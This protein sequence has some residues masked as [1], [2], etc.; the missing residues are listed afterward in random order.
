VG[1][2]SE[3]ESLSKQDIADLIDTIVNQKM[4]EV[5]HKT[6][7]KIKAAVDPLSQKIDRIDNTINNNFQAF[8][9]TINQN[10]TDTIT[11]MFQ[12]FGMHQTTGLITPPSNLAP[13]STS[14]RYAALS[15]SQTY[16]SPTATGTA[17][18]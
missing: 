14:N 7:Q 4:A 1:N 12:S 15:A 13:V 18:K 2:P 17:C 9:T 10:I 16:K 8:A 11:E 6:D 3:P 5:V